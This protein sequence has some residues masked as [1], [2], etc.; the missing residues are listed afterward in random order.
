MLQNDLFYNFSLGKAQT[1]RKLFLNASLVQELKYGDEL[2]FQ[3]IHCTNQLSVVFDKP[4]FANKNSLFQIKHVLVFPLDDE[5]DEERVAGTK[6]V[7]LEGCEKV[8]A[9]PWIS[10]AHK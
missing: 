7:I 1:L 4:S 3:F 9:A 5:L 6:K 8:E 10:S 2:S